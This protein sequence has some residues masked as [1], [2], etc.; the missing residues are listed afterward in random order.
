MCVSFS[1]RL[2][3]CRILNEGYVFLALTLMLKSSCVKELDVSNNNFGESKSG[4]KLLSATLKDPKVEA[5][6]YVLH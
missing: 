5:L 4:W 1:L 6:Q 2:S 3:N